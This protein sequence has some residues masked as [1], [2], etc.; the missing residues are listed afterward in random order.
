MPIEGETKPCSYP[1]CRGTLTYHMRAKAPGRA[2]REASA[3]VWGAEEQ[4]GWECDA[5]REHFKPL[6][7]R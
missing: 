5:D 7:S 1:G 4:P 6:K 2:P 3:V